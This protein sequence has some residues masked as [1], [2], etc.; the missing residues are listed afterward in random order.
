[1]ITAPYNFVPLNEEVFYPDWSEHVSHDV[2]FEDGESGEIEI[3]IEAKSPIFIRDSKDGEKFCHH[4]STHYIPGSSIK[5][6]VRNILEIMSFSKM[7]NDSFNDDTYAV[8]DLSSAKNFYMKQMQEEKFCGWLVKEGDKLFIEDCGTPARIHLNQIDYAFGIE[9]AKY[10]NSN[11][12]D[13]QNKE[14]KTAKYKYELLGGT[15]KKI[16]V[17]DIYK[18]KTNPKYDT[19]EFCT[20]QKDGKEGTL[21]LT[22]Q[23]TK[24]KDTGKMGDGK[25]FEFVFF[26]SRK[27]IEVT[28]N[29]WENFL[30]AYFDKRE[31]EPKE[32]PDWS[33]WKEK[34]ESGEKVPVFFQKNMNA[35]AH[36]GLSYLYKLPY[37]HSI[38]DGI[39]ASHFSSK[40]D[41]TQIIFG[42]VDKDEQKALKGR[43]QFSHFKAIK[44]AIELKPRSAILGSPRASYY[45][46]YV[47]QNA[48]KLFTT[49][50]NDNFSISGWK[51]YPVHKGVQVTTTDDT[52]NTYVATTFCPLKEGVIFEGKLRYHNLKKAEL[53]ALL[54]ALTYHD[55]RNCYH[56]IGLAKSLGYG[57][58]KISIK[59]IKDIASYL[60]EFELHIGEQIENWEN[61]VQI[62]ELL[63]M[64]MEQ[65]NQQNSKLRYMKLEEFAKNKSQTKDY[66]RPYTELDNIKAIKVSSFISEEERESFIKRREEFLKKVKEDEKRRAE[67]ELL[68]KEQKIKGEKFKEAQKTDNLQIIRNFIEKYPDYDGVE[69]LKN[70]LSL[71]ESKLQANKHKEVEAAAK[72]AFNALKS[73]YG[74]KGYDKDKAKFIKKWSAE[75]NNKGSKYI[76]ELVKTLKEEK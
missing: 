32:S 8:R 58:I 29:V 43:V 13:A 50:M 31:T 47:K 20:Y 22:G 53:G 41:L 40:P 16:K 52:G 14:H 54:S 62:R 68:K 4:Q 30:F 11:I 67:E 45:P 44:G 26:E 60:K 17:S 9:F 36:F 66:L 19:R 73:K 23:P 3:T 39:P 38:K 28:T 69:E 59:N 49:Y 48:N 46:I 61:S 37:K 51:R 12:F 74:K 33:F 6:M 10:F 24:R 75:K 71:E 18:S 27:K 42:Y 15:H 76:L 25:G 70:K 2:P 56:N 57:K 63:S 5:G 34:L 1:M 72:Y 65:D 35:I 64:A 21:V 7:S 55:T